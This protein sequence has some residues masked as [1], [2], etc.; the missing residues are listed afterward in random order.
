[1]DAIMLLTADHNRVRGLFTKFRT[2]HENDDTAEMIEVAAKI[3]E[4][5]DVHTEIEEQIFYPAIRNA[6]EELGEEVAEGVEEHHVVK[7]LASEIEA[8]TPGA[9]DWTAKVTVVTELVEHHAEE[10]ET[11]MFPEV[12]KLFDA[13]ALAD[14]G[15]QMESLKARLGA[16]T[17]KDKEQLSTEQL[18]KLASE[19]EIPGRSSMNREE[20]LATVAPG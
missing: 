10:E 20:L 19:Q 17:A 11:E 15:Q 2:A 18:K 4:E 7:V 12:K 9:E 14:L 5:L 13:N 8:M 6:D 3:L 1:M 16:P